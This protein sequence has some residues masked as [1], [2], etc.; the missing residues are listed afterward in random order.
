MSERD[1]KSL[2][3]KLWPRG[4]LHPCSG[5]DSDLE[6]LF[7]GI[8]K[9]AKLLDCEARDLL[10]EVM[11]DQTGRFLEDWERVLGL[12]L[13]DIPFGSREERRDMVIAMLNLGVFSSVQFLID[14]AKIFGFDI[15]I[16]EFRPFRA[17]SS[18]A[19]DPLNS[20]IQNGTI[21]ITAEC[22]DFTFFRAGRS[23]AG[24]RLLSCSNEA[25]ICIINFF[26][27]ANMFVI[28]KFI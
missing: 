10:N 27:H 2:L 17:G 6:K 3:F 21:E 22:V 12:P 4:D 14:V 28:F 13:C 16:V 9:E 11:P 26:K 7:D 24:E 19:G 25:L 18:S 8:A 20:Q 15:T 23:G 1:Y 5:D